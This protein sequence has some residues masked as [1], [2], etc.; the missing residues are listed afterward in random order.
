[1]N[2]P[3]LMGRFRSDPII[4]LW[5]ASNTVRNLNDNSL[6]EVIESM[7][8]GEG[9]WDVWF[10]HSMVAPEGAHLT[11]AMMG[12]RRGRK[13]GQKQLAMTPDEKRETD[14]AGQAR[15]PFMGTFGAQ[16]EPK[17]IVIESTPPDR[18][19]IYHERNFP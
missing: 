7:V 11:A 15:A 2:L 3:R 19:N 14:D 1:M 17:P 4:E 10:E 12:E 16:A 9:A 6:G 13:G 5:R 8:L 18:P